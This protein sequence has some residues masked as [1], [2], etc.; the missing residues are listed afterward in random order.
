MRASGS[1]KTRVA[2]A[3]ALA[4][5][6]GPGPRARGSLV[7]ALV[8]AM[9]ALAGGAPPPC[10]AAEL[11]P[12][13]RLPIAGRAA[14]GP[15]ID[16]GRKPEAAWILSEDR[17][18]YLLSDAGALISH[19]V[20]SDRPLSFLAVDPAGRALVILAP[21]SGPA[22]LAAYTRLGRESWRASLESLGR[23]AGADGSATGRPSGGTGGGSA[24]G[25][26]AMAGGD[27]LPG[28]AFGADERIFL[29]YVRR[30]LCLSQAVRRLW[31]LDLPADCVL[32]PALDGAGRL[33]LALSDGSLAAISPYGVV[34]ALVD[35]GRLSALG[36]FA[37]APWRADAAAGAQAASAVEPLVA[38]GTEGGEVLLMDRRGGILSRLALPQ[39]AGP[40][41]SFASDGK[42]LYVLTKAGKVSGIASTGSLLWSAEAGVRDGRLSLYP[43]RL[44]A[45][46]TGR[47]VS[48]SL[49]GNIL[50]EAAFTNATGPCVLSPSGLLYSPGADWVLGAYRFEKV[51]GPRIEPLAPAYGDDP[52]AVRMVLDLDP[53]AGDSRHRIDILERFEA[54]LGSGSLGSDEGRAGALASGMA[55]GLFEGSWPQQQ[56]VLHSDPWSRAM[57]VRLLG[58]LGS[59][60]RVPLILRVFREDADPSVRSAACRALAA[61]GRDPTGEAGAAF[62][63]AASG[64]KRLDAETAVALI[65][66]IESLV[67][68]SSSPPVD[69][70]R[71]LLALSAAPNAPDVRNAAAKALGRLAGNLG[72]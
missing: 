55:L 7:P 63:A 43:D 72:P 31:A 30:A 4:V 69:A 48:V 49:W 26:A 67:L 10:A 37:R 36:A 70:V 23:L 52:A 45:T 29:A 71:A 15:V 50:K 53:S 9:A 35:T 3:G 18:L 56:A 13:F 17:S 44:V 8:L 27:G 58:L 25:A 39:G 41:L 59:P 62:Y 47:A 38:A 16:E 66:A 11:E 22:V 57:A 19:I 1:A 6:T 46:G 20:P 12:S 28:L 5:S 51:L 54:E 65:S 40:A 33:L 2:A 61:I 64:V 32:P 68:S 21:T 34:E 42:S 24:A 60:E 14:A